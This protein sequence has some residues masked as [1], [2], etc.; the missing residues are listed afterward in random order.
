MDFLPHFFQSLE[1][2]G[3]TQI[4]VANNEEGQDRYASLL[5]SLIDKYLR[6]SYKGTS[7][8]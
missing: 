3:K 6:M 8:E 7:R 2:F 1:P 5:G 4:F